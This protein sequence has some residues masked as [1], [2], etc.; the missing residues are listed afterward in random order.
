METKKL[1]EL[2]LGEKGVVTAVHADAL[3]TDQLLELGIGP[4]EEISFEGKS[5][6]GDPIIIGLMNY[7]L[8]LRKAQAEK[9]LLRDVKRAR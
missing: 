6:F 1:S 9:I 4:G 3:L 2:V 8:A 7:Q 5:P